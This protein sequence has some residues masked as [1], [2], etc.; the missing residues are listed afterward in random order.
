[1]VRPQGIVRSGGAEWRGTDEGGITIN[2]ASRPGAVRSSGYNAGSGAV[3]TAP[4]T[5]GPVEEVTTAMS[6]FNRAL[7]APTTG[8]PRRAAIYCRVSSA[9]QE[10]N[11]SLDTQEAACRAYAAERS[12][13]VVEVYREVHTG[14]ELFD[15]L[16]LSALRDAVRRRETDVVLAYALDRLTRN[17]AHLGFLL[18]EW[19]H[20]GVRLELVTEE[21]DETPEGRLL[22][23]VRGF[24]AEMERLK[25]AERTRRGIR[26]R[27][28]Q[29]K[30]LVGPRPIYG[31]RWRDAGKAAL[32]LNPET[33][34]VVRWIFEAMLKGETLRSVAGR[35]TAQG[36][37]TPTGRNPRWSAVTVRG[38]LTM[39]Q[40]TGHATPFRWRVERRKGHKRTTLREAKDQLSLPDGTIPA[41]VTPEE[42]AAVAARLEANQRT[43]SRNSSDPEA[44]LLRTG[45]VR[46]G[47]CGSPLTVKNPCP[48][49][50]GDRHYRCASVNRERFGCPAIQI[51]T[52]ILDSAVWRRVEAV[53]TRP[54]IIAAEVARR[55]CQDPFA[56]ELVVIDR[57]LAEIATR[58]QRLA[59]A[60]AALDDEETSAPLLQEA[61]ALAEQKQVLA[62]EREHMATLRAE[63]QADDDR[64]A[65][66][67]AWCARVAGNLDTLSYQERRMVL[68]ALGV[69][70]KLFR[71]DHTPR[72]ELTMAPLPMSPGEPLVFRTASGSC[73]TARRFSSTASPILPSCGV[74]SATRR[75]LSTS[76]ATARAATSS[77]SAARPRS[78]RRNRRRTR[79][80]PTSRSTGRRCPG[81]R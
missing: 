50:P 21:F 6:Q 80:W 57:R 18:S 35:L 25:I 38:I 53:L 46:C 8:G 20:L 24:V 75:W 78:P 2:A 4:L 7:V 13:V 37:S 45:V 33:A 52:E 26:A 12:C 59:R 11:S 65:T 71:A 61:K 27:A 79:S 14:T 62:A 30:L 81:L 15:R 5:V 48:S 32:E 69:A 3:N 41:I 64:L 66:L 40:Y 29:G 10:D 22:Q 9:G 55:R 56:A 68:E 36:V 19:D 1:M 51:Q 60:V 77:C 43:A 39:P 58:R 44:A 70:V 42:F 31:Y 23:S 63:S 67:A 54:D 73:G 72:W 34:P 49:H 17:Q 28:E 16:Q 74:S 76:T 47:Y